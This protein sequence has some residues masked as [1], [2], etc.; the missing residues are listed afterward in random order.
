MSVN[1]NYYN[2]QQEHN[3]Y[4]KSSGHLFG[5]LSKATMIDMTANMKSRKRI[6]ASSE[7]PVKGIRGW[8]SQE[9]KDIKPH[10]VNHTPQNTA[11][12]VLI[13]FMVLPFSI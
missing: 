6:I 3:V 2:Q 12:N 4:Y 7:D 11:K 10:T 5:F 8:R 13:L 9:M 1:F